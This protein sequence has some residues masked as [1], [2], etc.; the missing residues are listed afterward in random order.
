[1]DLAFPALQSI[2]ANRAEA[3]TVTVVSV[4]VSMRLP[5]PAANLIAGAESM[6]ASLIE[7]RA[8]WIEDEFLPNHKSLFDELVTS[9]AWDER[10]R[11]RKA[12]SFGL[13]YNYSGIEWPAAPFPVSLLPLLDQLEQK[14]GYR[15]NNCLAHFYADGN[16]TM[17][18]HSDSTDEL[19]PGT[20][21]AVISL[22]SERTITFRNQSDRQH[23]ERYLLKSG[24]LLYMTPQMQRDWKHG[25]LQDEN[26]GSRISLTFRCMKTG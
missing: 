14:L 26:V 18:F 9:V 13:P 4:S 2:L 10:I 7:S 21:I 19:A 6:N 3:G 17:G 11:A 5:G 24:S 15:S 1:M 23:L 16:S 20:G 8:L 22:G 25:I 12:A